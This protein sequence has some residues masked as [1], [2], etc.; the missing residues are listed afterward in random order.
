MGNH[1]WDENKLE[2]TLRNMPETKDHRSKEEIL[3]R[4]K[5][6]DRLQNDKIKQSSKRK[7]PKWVPVMVAIAAVF[8]ISILVPA[9][10]KTEQ[11]ATMDHAVPESKETAPAMEESQDSAEDTSNL[12]IATFSRGL[13][14]D[15]HFAVYPSDL[16]EQTAFH[17]GLATDQSTI[18]PVTF[19]IPNWQ[20]EEDFE[21]AQPDALTLYRHY[22]PLL[23]E[24]ALGFTDYH[25]YLAELSSE[26]TEIRMKFTDEQA[27]DTSS[28]TLEMLN[29]S[30][31]DTFT[32]YDDV[33]FFRHDG[34]PMVFDQVGEAGKLELY[35]QQAGQAFY[36]FTQSNGETYLSSNFG[37]TFQMVEEALTAMKETPNDVFETVVP[38]DVDFTAA[39][40][41][42]V[43]NVRF[44]DELDLESRKP[45]D[46]M[47][48]I[49]GILL[50]AAGFGVQVEFEQIKQNEWRDFDFS[51][52]IP[53]PVGAN[54]K[55]LILK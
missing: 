54:P 48:L 22:A 46:A 30:V 36:R 21:T 31:Q 28:A 40:E 41:D 45:E 16:Q 42:G 15:D 14:Q 7:S 47:Q 10:F 23:D 9:L 49:E 27:Y 33:R 6:D 50:T 44:T 1:K 43:V 18:M 13:P 24:E 26:G 29:Q 37:K 4:L 32:G 17:I 52:P 55:N 8:L 12:D 51:A 35:G 11:Q 38:D 39:E 53:I 34:N 25:P 20:I 19:L 3:L 5:K 2:E